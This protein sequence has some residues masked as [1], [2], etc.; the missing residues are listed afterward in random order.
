V[1]PELVFER[2]LVY[3]ISSLA[4]VFAAAIFHIARLA[5]SRLRI[6]FP[7]AQHPATA[8]HSLTGLSLE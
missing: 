7:A 8:V 5:T 2:R 3:P 1:D 4:V 6:L